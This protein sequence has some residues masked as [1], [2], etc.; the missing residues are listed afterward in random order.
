LIDT[1][2]LLPLLLRGDGN[3]R[4][5]AQQTHSL[6]NRAVK[7]FYQRVLHAKFLAF[8][9]GK[10]LC[11]LARQQTAVSGALHSAAIVSAREKCVN[12]AIETLR[13]QQIARHQLL[14]SIP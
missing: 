5:F 4:L 10:T 8:H 14:R 3:V 1:Y 7:I 12:I 11:S 2:S 13:Q 6:A 9:Y